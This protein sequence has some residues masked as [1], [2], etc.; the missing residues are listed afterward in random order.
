M[1]YAAGRQAHVPLLAGWNR[2]ENTSL[3][4]GMT[5][6]KWKAYADQHFKEGAAE[7]LKLY[8]GDTDEQALA[9]PRGPGTTRTTRSF[10]WTAPLPPARRPCARATS[11]CCRECRRCSIGESGE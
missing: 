10:T 7:F 5:V 6:A 8:P 9:C 1:T 3:A 2:D 4:N 11:F